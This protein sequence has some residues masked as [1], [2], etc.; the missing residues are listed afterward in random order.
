MLTVVACVLA[1]AGMI[2]YRMFLFDISWRNIYIYTT[3]LWTFFSLLQIVLIL[4]LNVHV[5]IPNFYFALGDTAAAAIIIAIQFMPSCIMY[6]ML[7]PEGSEGLVYAVLTT[8]NN[9][10][11]SVASNIGSLFTLLW[12]V[13]NDT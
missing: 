4:Q 7:C 10:S 5:G 8:I 2:I 11:S 12:D 9:L 3:L 6:A 1:W 13:R